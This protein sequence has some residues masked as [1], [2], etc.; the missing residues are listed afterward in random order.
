MLNVLA[1]QYA[2]DSCN[3]H[4]FLSINRRLSIVILLTLFARRRQSTHAFSAQLINVHWSTLHS[5]QSAIKCRKLFVK[6]NVYSFFRSSRP[7]RTVSKRFQHIR[8]QSNCKLSGQLCSVE[9]GQ[10]R[11]LLVKQIWLTHIEYVVQAII[12]FVSFSRFQ[13]KIKRFRQ[14]IK[15]QQRQLIDLGKCDSFIEFV[16]RCR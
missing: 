5:V 12:I 4:T 10:A 6:G 11:L 16:C 14:I 9:I 13:D 8:L 2:S 1:S 7:K 15:F 3:W